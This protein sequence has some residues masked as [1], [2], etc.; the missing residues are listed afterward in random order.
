MTVL[1]RPSH[2]EQ[3][4]NAK[5]FKGLLRWRVTIR[6]F[7]MGDEDKDKEEEKEPEVELTEEQKQNLLQQEM[8]DKIKQMARL[9]KKKLVKRRKQQARFSMRMGLHTSMADEEFEAPHEGV[10]FSLMY[11]YLPR[12]LNFSGM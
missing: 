3:V 7:A 2:H 1:T 10:L 4:L 6:N 11:G 9:R 8:D 5:D 12:L